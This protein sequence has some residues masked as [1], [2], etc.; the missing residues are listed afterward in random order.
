MLNFCKEQL[1]LRF[2]NDEFQAENLTSVSCNSAKSIMQCYAQGCKNKIMASHLLNESSS[3]SH[4]IFTIK[5]Q[6][7]NLT[8]NE[9]LISNVHGVDLA[10]S[11]RAYQ[12]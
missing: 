1:K 3:R 11:E 12:S 7:T 8:T 10:G 4:C 9:T 2:R 5:L 6:K